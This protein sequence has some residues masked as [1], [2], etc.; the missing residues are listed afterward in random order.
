MSEQSTRTRVRRG[1]AEW[2]SLFEAQASSGLSQLRFCQQQGVSLSAFYNAKS[3][4]AAELGGGKS[5]AHEDFFALTLPPLEATG[6][7]DIELSLGGDIVL[8]MRR[9]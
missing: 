1:K 3:R 9:G 4:Y 2:L 6:G 7:W 5:S 8:R